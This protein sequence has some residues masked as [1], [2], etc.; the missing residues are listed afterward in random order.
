MRHLNMRPVGRDANFHLFLYS[1]GAFH[2][3]HRVDMV[4]VPGHFYRRIIRVIGTRLSFGSMPQ[5]VAAINAPVIAAGPT[6]ML[7]IFFKLVLSTHKSEPDDAW[8]DI[9]GDHQ[10]DN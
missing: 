4:V 9:G 7:V 5:A 2:W 1:S 8:A 10:V 6:D 3:L